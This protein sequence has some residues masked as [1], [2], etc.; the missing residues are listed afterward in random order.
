MANG[1]MNVGDSPDSMIAAMSLPLMTHQTTVSCQYPFVIRCH[2]DHWELL[3]DNK[4]WTLALERVMIRPGVNGV[5]GSTT[6]TSMASFNIDQ[7][8]TYWRK[9]GDGRWRIIEG[10]GLGQSSEILGK[11]FPGSPVGSKSLLCSGR[12]RTDTGKVSNALIASWEVIDGRGRVVVDYA[13]YKRIGDIV[14]KE[15]FGLSEPGPFAKTRVIEKL[16]TALSQAE[17]GVS[18]AGANASP[19]AKR[20]LN[21]LREKVAFAS[22]D[23]SA[24]N[25]TLTPTPVAAKRIRYKT[26]KDAQADLLNLL[27][28]MDPAEL[29]ALLAATEVSNG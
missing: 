13:E 17:A 2:P 28:S 19:D 25:P 18:R 22:G 9:V 4:G 16:Y 7:L 21:K 15:M 8:L 3:P 29:K 26:S 12:V 5:G 14:A 27:R 10:G 20:R 23:N 11:I 24:L 1:F 6:A